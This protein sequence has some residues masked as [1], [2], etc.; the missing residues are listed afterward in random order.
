MSN[1]KLSKEE[2]IALINKTEGRVNIEKQIYKIGSDRNSYFDRNS[3]IW[4]RYTKEEEG[5]DLIQFLSS[6]IDIIRDRYSYNT[7][8][9]LEDILEVIGKEAEDIA[10]LQEFLD[11]EEKL[12]EET[13][14]FFE[15]DILPLSLSDLE[16]KHKKIYDALI[17]TLNEL[18]DDD[19]DVNDDTVSGMLFDCEYP[20][21]KIR[22][23]QDEGLG[24][25][26]VYFSP[27]RAEDEE[28]ANECGLIPFKFDDEFYL[29]LGGCGMDLSPKLDAYIALTIGEIPSNSVFFGDKDYFKYVIGEST[30]KKV[31]AKITRE[32]PKYV[33]SFNL[34]S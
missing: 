3:S 21:D 8:N 18:T 19:I 7:D 22:E 17:E 27:N 4:E 24:Y 11:N 31:L 23:V 29:A 13:E 9:T 30:Y 33:I 34:S 28:I 6:K 12:K 15:S 14:D 2:I 16:K 20:S 25:W 32:V 10:G 5:Y 26:T 1:L